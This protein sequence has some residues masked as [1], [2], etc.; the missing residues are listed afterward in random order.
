MNNNIK[1]VRIQNALSYLKD[2]TFEQI[3]DLLNNHIS[4]NYISKLSDNLANGKV[5]SFI[6]KNIRSLCN[7]LQPD[8]DSVEADSIYLAFMFTYPHLMRARTLEDITYGTQT[9]EYIDETIVVNAGQEVENNCVNKRRANIADLADKIFDK[10]YL[11]SKI[12]R[13]KNQVEVAY[14]FSLLIC[15]AGN[16]ANFIDTLIHNGELKIDCVR[17]ALARE[18]IKASNVTIKRTYETLRKLYHEE[19]AMDINQ[20]INNNL[21]S[22]KEYYK[23]LLKDDQDPELRELCGYALIGLVREY[24]SEVFE[25]IQ[26]CKTYTAGQ[27]GS[28][29][30]ETA[31]DIILDFLRIYVAD[32][33]EGTSPVEDM[34]FAISDNMSAY[35]KAIAG[36]RSIC[37]LLGKDSYGGLSIMA[38]VAIMA[39]EMMEPDEYNRF[40]VQVREKMMMLDKNKVDAI[41]EKYSGF[42]LKTLDYFFNTTSYNPATKYNEAAI[43]RISQSRNADELIDKAWKCISLFNDDIDSTPAHASILAEFAGVAYK[44]GKTRQAEDTWQ[45]VFNLGY[46][47]ALEVIINHKNGQSNQQLVEAVQESAIAFNL[48]QENDIIDACN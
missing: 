6:S 10:E 3:M 23:E 7:N 38:S 41:R 45:N 22:L 18:G 28:P 32:D 40:F 1:H 35:T 24:A 9:N 26:N 31:S 44:A 36:A 17:K 14:G 4:D 19:T 13:A 46:E 48:V 42:G 20:S 11:A 16:R 37:T 15:E 39:Y 25:T 21:E 34:A 30:A 2:Q 8:T 5:D 47:N 27:H 29:D 43:S 12:T 33:Q